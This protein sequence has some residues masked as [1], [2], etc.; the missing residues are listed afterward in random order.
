MEPTKLRVEWNKKRTPR[1]CW[2]GKWY[3]VQA[4]LDRWKDTGEWWKGDT[5]KLF[6]RLLAGQGVW[7]VYR[8]LQSGEW[9][10]YRRY[11]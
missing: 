7:E 5:P 8:D 11:D 4:M 9:F 2:Q 3:T 6:L 10:L 1:F